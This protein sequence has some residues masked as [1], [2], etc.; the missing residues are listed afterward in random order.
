MAQY[1][2]IS[3]P[4]V[5]KFVTFDLVTSIANISLSKVSFKR[6]GQNLKIRVILK[7]VK[8]PM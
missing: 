3:N 4:Q 7:T 5:F 8:Y 1:F 6:Q 2:P